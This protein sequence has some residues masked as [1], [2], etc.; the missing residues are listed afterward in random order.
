MKTSYKS[1]RGKETKQ[2]EGSENLSH[3]LS[4]KPRKTG[5]LPGP[6]DEEAEMRG[7]PMGELRMPNRQHRLPSD[8][9]GRSRGDYSGAK[10]SPY[11][12]C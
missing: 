4:Y 9:V 8:Q 11:P 5:D 7:P 6:P 2:Q 1:G 10:A 3:S 12:L